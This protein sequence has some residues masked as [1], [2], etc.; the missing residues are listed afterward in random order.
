MF[1]YGLVFPTLCVQQNK[2][3]S[4]IQCDSNYFNTFCPILPVLRLLRVPSLTR[5]CE[6]SNSQP[7]MDRQIHCVTN[8]VVYPAVTA[9]AA[10]VMAVPYCGRGREFLILRNCISGFWQVFWFFSF[11]VVCVVVSRHFLFFWTWRV[12]QTLTVTRLSL[13]K[14]MLF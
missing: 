10:V 14:L 2:F 4:V 12:Q 7:W 3:V 1:Q 6:L 11:L 13:R 5:A 9:C 8:P